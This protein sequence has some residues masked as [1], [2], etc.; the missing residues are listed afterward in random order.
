M[1]KPE[2]IES[3]KAYAETG[4]PTGGFLYAVLSNN[5]SESFGRAD[6]ENRLALYEIVQYIYHNIPADS[7]GSTAKVEAWLKAKREEREFVPMKNYPD[8]DEK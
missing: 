2:T 1:I 8:P 6:L 3:I 4:R 5:L 7:W